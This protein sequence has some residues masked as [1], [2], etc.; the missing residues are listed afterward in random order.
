MNAARIA[1]PVL[2]VVLASAGL[3]SAAADAAPPVAP[4]AVVVPRDTLAR[5]VTV[6]DVRVDGATVTGTAVNSSAR[7]LRDVTLLVRYTWLWNDERHPGKDTVSRVAYVT[8][9]VELRPGES[10]TFTYRPDRPLPARRD[11]RF[12]SKVD[13]AEV[14]ALVPEREAGRA[15]AGRR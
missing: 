12:A 14:V 8:V 13:V 15:T 5:D 11:G 7:P 1:A 9:P 2:G 6:R 10:K 3:A 4:D